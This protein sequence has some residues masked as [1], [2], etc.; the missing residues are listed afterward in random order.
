MCNYTILWKAVLTQCD[1]PRGAIRNQV[2]GE[3]LDALAS[4][5]TIFESESVGE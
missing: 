2:V 1:N 4:L 5:G 3:F